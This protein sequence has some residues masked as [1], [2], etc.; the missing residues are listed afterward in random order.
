MSAHN[1]LQQ[2]RDAEHVMADP[3]N[4][5]GIY[6]DRDQCQVE[7]VSGASGETRSLPIPVRAGLTLTM[8]LRT[9]GGGN[10]VVTAA[11]AINAA[12]N[13]IMTFADARD[14][15]VLQA[16]TLG[17]AIAWQVVSNEGVALS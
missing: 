2:M 16:I 1:L 8:V 12:G 4:G 14:F 5:K 9:D 17:S 3:G 13:T 6:P 7:F 11:S 10:V 15:I